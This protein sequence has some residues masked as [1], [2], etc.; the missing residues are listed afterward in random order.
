MQGFSC[1]DMPQKVPQIWVAQASDETN[2]NGLEMIGTMKA[3][4]DIL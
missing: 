1:G 4:V 3:N 2:D